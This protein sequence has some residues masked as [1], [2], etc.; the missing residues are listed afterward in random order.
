MKARDV[1]LVMLDHAGGSISGRTLIQKRGYFLDRMLA[2]GLGYRAHYYGPYSGALDA[3]IGQ[4]RALGFVEE[5]A[6]GYGVAGDAGFEVRRYD[7]SLTPDGRVVA[8]AVLDTDKEL[9]GGIRACLD[10]IAAAGDLGAQQLSIAAK[11]VWVLDARGQP[12]TPK[13]ISEEGR[14]LGW[15][16][17]DEDVSRVVG[18]L[19]R[20]G[21]VTCDDVRST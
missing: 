9:C 13:S 17:S 18:F 6:I 8:Q 10:R 2:L 12:M 4:C 20:L 16:V 21:L 15:S 1:F 11:V 5:R 14:S 19:K 7:Y 3:A